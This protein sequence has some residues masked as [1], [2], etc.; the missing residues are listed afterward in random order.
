MKRLIKRINLKKIKSTIK[1]K[2]ILLADRGR[3]ES[4]FKNYSAIK[5][6][7]TKF[8]IEPIVLTTKVFKSSRRGSL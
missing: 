4:V 2:R 7:E 1:G 6:L 5:I 8:K 3:F